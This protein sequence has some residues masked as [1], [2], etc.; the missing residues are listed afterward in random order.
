MP[1]SAQLFCILR[2]HGAHS[3]CTLATKQFG[4]ETTGRLRMCGLILLV[5]KSLV[6]A[7][8]K[9]TQT[10]ITWIAFNLTRSYIT[11]Q[12]AR[13]FPQRFLNNEYIINYPSWGSTLTVKPL[14]TSAHLGACVI[15]ANFRLDLDNIL[16]F[17][18]WERGSKPLTSDSLLVA[19]RENRV[20][21][22]IWYCIYI[23]VI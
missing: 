2:H 8:G 4:E 19:L 9:T 20:T 13:N 1:P 21:L 5:G 6:A 23:S 22:I 12:S 18:T 16:I 7:H 17:S 14:A 15:V 10:H 3:R 11:S